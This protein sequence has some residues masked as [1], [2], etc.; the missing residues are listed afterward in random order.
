MDLTNAYVGAKR[1]RRTVIHLLPGYAVVLDEAE[2]ETAEEI[3]LR[4]HTASAGA[5]DAAGNFRVVNGGHVLACRIES[6]DGEPDSIGLKRHA[7]AAPYNRDRTGQLLEQRNEPYVE[8]LQKRQAC[9]ILSLFGDA[10]LGTEGL[11]E[12]SGNSW[13]L[14]TATGRVEVICSETSLRIRHAASRRELAVDLG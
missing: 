11:W 2:L 5:P 1:V 3:S 7:Y 10:G 4:W 13:E 8:L 12:N 9:R 6:L 14:A